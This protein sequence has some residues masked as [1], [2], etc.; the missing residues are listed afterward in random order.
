MIH[1]DHLCF[2]DLIIYKFICDWEVI[3]LYT[4]WGD[5]SKPAETQ[6]GLLG[7]LKLEHLTSLVLNC[8]CL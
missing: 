6:T 8:T 7:V 3:V 4:V 5:G 1:R 2:D